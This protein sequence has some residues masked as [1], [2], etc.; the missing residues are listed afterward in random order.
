[1]V[2]FIRLLHQISEDQRILQ[3]WLCVG[4]VYCKEALCTELRMILKRN[5]SSQLS[6]PSTHRITEQPGDQL[7]L[8]SE[9]FKLSRHT[10][11]HTTPIRNYPTVTDRD[12]PPFITA[13]ITIDL[14]TVNQSSQQYTAPVQ[15]QVQVPSA[16]KDQQSSQ[17]NVQN[18]ASRPAPYGSGG[19][20][21]PSNNSYPAVRNNQNNSNNNNNNNSSYNSRDSQN[22]SRSRS[23]SPQR[24]RDSRPGSGSNFRRSRLVDCIVDVVVL[25]RMSDIGYEAD[26]VCW[27]R[28][29]CGGAADN[30]MKAGPL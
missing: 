18:S 25:L 15:V 12:W 7:T 16:R 28:G 27:I 9:N 21:N 24:G 11:H 1:M 4:A 22:R 23:R 20:N 17:G 14:M 13:I 5:S 6:V 2:T 26:A 3:K 8:F 29:V 30:V 10:P 19:R